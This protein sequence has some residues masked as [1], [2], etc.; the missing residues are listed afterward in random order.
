[1][2]DARQNIR[3]F[4]V[5]G[6]AM[7]SG[8]LEELVYE[9]DT[10]SFPISKLVKVFKSWVIIIITFTQHHPHHHH[11]VAQGVGVWGDQG[12]DLGPLEGTLQI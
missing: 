7:V 12:Q 11:Q 3:F 8:V 5:S 9:K 10:K 1:M 4:R 2:L 6:E